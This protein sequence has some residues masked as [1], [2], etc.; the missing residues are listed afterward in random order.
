MIIGILSYG[1]YNN[2]L[3]KKSTIFA[4]KSLTLTFGK[5]SRT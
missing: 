4:N 3:E 5:I 2:N 1:N